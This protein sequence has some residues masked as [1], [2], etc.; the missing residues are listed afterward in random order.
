MGEQYRGELRLADHCRETVAAQQI[1]ISRAGA[2]G[3]GVDLYRHL[4]PQSACDDRALGM[5]HRFLGREP[6]LA[7][8]FVDQR[9]VVGQAQQLAV[10]QAVGAAVAHMRDRHLLLAYVDGGE[11]RAHARLL[12]V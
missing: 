8:E 10:A 2:E 6:A 9:V 3:A 5:L 11:R 4:R 7:H 1:D 12:G